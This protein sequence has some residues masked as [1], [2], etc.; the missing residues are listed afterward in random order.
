MQSH[1]EVSSPVRVSLPASVA[2]E[3]GQ[4]KEVTKSVLGKLGCDNCC[5]GHNLYFEI[6]RDIALGN[7]KDV[8]IPSA[9]RA[10]SGFSDLDSGP[11]PVRVG[12]NPETADSIDNVMVALDRIADLS[13]HSACCSGR[14]LFMDLERIFVINAR[15]DLEEQILAIG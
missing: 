14:D 2:A 11:S 8:A 4:L 3:I 5:S 15:M 10:A 12:L 6:Q 1:S 9:R 13:G 7:L